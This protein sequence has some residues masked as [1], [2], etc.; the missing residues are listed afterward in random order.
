MHFFSCFYLHM[1]RKYC[2]FA[3]YKRCSFS[4]RICITKIKKYDKEFTLELIAG[5]AAS[6]GIEC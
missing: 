4:R 3:I 6:G 5:D 1:S 2:I